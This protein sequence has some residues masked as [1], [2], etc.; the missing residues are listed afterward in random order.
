MSENK[1]ILVID[2]ESDCREFTKAILE[3]EGWELV[4]AGQFIPDK[5]TLA[6]ECL[7]DIPALAEYHR[8]LCDPQSSENEVRRT[9]A[10][11][12]RECEENFS[13]W[14]HERRK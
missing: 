9:K 13:R 7:D 3:P 4:P 2:D 12:I 5:K 8:A 10:D 1:K 11:V 6:E 14:M